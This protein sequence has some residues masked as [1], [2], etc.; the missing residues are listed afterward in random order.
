MNTTVSPACNPLSL[1]GGGYNCQPDVT[2]V[3]Q[4]RWRGLDSPLQYVEKRGTSV[5]LH[6]SSNKNITQKWYFKRSYPT[7]DGTYVIYSVEDNS[8]LTTRS[9]Q[10]TAEMIQSP[11]DS[12]RFSIQLCDSS[13]F[14]FVANVTSNLVLGLTN[15]SSQNTVTMLNFSFHNSNNVGANNQL[16]QFVVQGKKKFS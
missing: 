8:M 11:S 1:A 13:C 10:L 12:E 6:Q 4:I 14:I 7:F 5:E 15:I 9:G 3:Y 16:W 2:Q